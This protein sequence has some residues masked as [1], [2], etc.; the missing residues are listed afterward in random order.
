MTTPWPTNGSFTPS[1]SPLF[2]M[3]PYPSS[4]PSGAPNATFVELPVDATATI[5]AGTAIGAL[6]IGGLFVAVQYL[7]PQR[8]EK[9]GEKEKDK[10]EEQEQDDAT[11][12]IRLGEGLSY[13]CVATAD[14]EDVVRLLTASQKRF[15][16]LAANSL[17]PAE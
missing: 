8:R 11:V 6:G 13:L 3:I 16:V 14:L 12:G 2:M 5:V 4:S 9:K 10:E 17:S 15:H 7:K 1:S